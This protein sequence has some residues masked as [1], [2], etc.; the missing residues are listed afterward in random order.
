MEVPLRQILNAVCHFRLGCGAT[1]P[2][3][4]K[5][6][7]PTAVEPSFQTN[8]LSLLHIVLGQETG[9]EFLN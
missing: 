9:E 6:K 2:L 1:I 4:M 5:M 7:K 8:L 3:K